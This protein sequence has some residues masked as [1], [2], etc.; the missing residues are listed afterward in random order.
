MNDHIVCDNSESTFFSKRFVITGINKT[1][2]YHLSLS[3]T[4]SCVKTALFMASTRYI[5][6][7]IL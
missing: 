2:L 7:E 4:M 1:E 5:S 3:A 6:L